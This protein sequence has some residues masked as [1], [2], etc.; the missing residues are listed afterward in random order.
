MHTQTLDV[1]PPL[2]HKVTKFTIPLVGHEQH[3]F[4]IWSI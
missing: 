1:I 2:I 3:S 4:Q